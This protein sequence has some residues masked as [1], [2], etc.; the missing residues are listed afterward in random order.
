MPDAVQHELS[1]LC[2]YFTAN[3][4]PRLQRKVE[5]VSLPACQQLM[6][7]LRRILDDGVGFAVI[8]RLPLDSIPDDCLVDLYW[9]LG[10]YIGRPVAQKWSGEMIYD[11]RD[12]GQSYQYGVRGSHTTV[13]LVFH[14]DNAFARLP[15]DY[16][17]LLCR[18][19]AKQGGVSRF[20][21]L[22]SVHE[23]IRARSTAALE[24]L[25]RPMLFDRQKEHAEGAPPVTLAPFFTWK[26]DRLWARANSSL[27]R[28]GYTVADE[29]MDSELL[30]ALDLVD[31]VCR[32]EE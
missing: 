15:P 7:D 4:L 12:T 30:D 25:Y 20:C 13:E 17:G 14:V 1:M 31:D 11:V 9:V 27:V 23:K 2:D 21:S 24:R 28:K 8:D 18:Q 29:R 32:S 19:P 22:Y 26:R 3:P 5:D 16:V 6:A 10:Q